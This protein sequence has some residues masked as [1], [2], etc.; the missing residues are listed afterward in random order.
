MAALKEKNALLQ[1]QLD[2]QSAQMAV[3]ASAMK[4]QEERIDELLK[5]VVSLNEK[6]GGFFE[7]SFNK[8][9]G[10]ER[11]NVKAAVSAS[12]K[13]KQGGDPA[14]VSQQLEQPILE[15]QTKPPPVL[16]RILRRRVQS[17]SSRVPEQKVRRR[18]NV[19]EG[20]LKRDFKRG[21]SNGSEAVPGSSP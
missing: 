6:L 1:Q 15:S 20:I 17:C 12:E 7:A 11:G 4:R 10:N 13:K 18:F 8:V 3:Q 16:E 5:Q 9:N 19:P 2:S 14:P 21:D